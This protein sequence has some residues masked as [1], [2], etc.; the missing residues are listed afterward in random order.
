L[1]LAGISLWPVGK[2]IVSTEE[3]HRMPWPE[4]GHV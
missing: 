4:R 3:A 1:K 2:E